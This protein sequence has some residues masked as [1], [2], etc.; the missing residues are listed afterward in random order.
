MGIWHH[1]HACERHNRGTPAFM[2][3]GCGCQDFSSSS[4]LQ[5]TS[6]FNFNCAKQLPIST[7]P[8]VHASFFSNDFSIM[9]AYVPS[10]G[11][12][13][14]DFSMA[15]TSAAATTTLDGSPPL[16][17]ADRLNMLLHR[18]RQPSPIFE[19]I[20]HRTYSV[21]M[22]L[23]AEVLQLAAAPKYAAIKRLLD[24]A[25]SGT[26]AS[27]P[28]QSKQRTT[29]KVCEVLEML[30]A[31]LG[32]PEQAEGKKRKKRRRS[33]NGML[34]PHEVKQEP[35]LQPAQG[36]G[37]YPHKQ[38]SKPLADVVHL[39]YSLD[40]TP[41]RKRKRSEPTAA[42]SM[43][44][45]IIPD[46]NDDGDYDKSHDATGG[47]LFVSE[48]ESG[49]HTDLDSP[50]SDSEP[51]G[52]GS[53]R[54]AKQCSERDI[55]RFGYVSGIFAQN[56]L[57]YYIS[58]EATASH[59][60]LFR[61]TT[62]AA[63][64]YALISCRRASRAVWREQWYA[65]TCTIPN[66]T[67]ALLERFAS[68]IWCAVNG[69]QEAV[70]YPSEGNGAYSTT[71]QSSRAGA[72]RSS[73]GANQYEMLLDNLLGLPNSIVV[74]VCDERWKSRKGSEESRAVT[75]A[76][77]EPDPESESRAATIAKRESESELEPE[78]EARLA[79][80][81]SSPRS[82]MEAKK[83]TEKSAAGTAAFRKEMAK[84]R[85][86]RM[87]NSVVHQALTPPPLDLSSPSQPGLKTLVVKLNT[88]DRRAAAR[89]RLDDGV[90]P[91]LAARRRPGEQEDRDAF[92]R[93][94]E[95]GSCG[96][97][98][99]RGIA[100]ITP[101]SVVYWAGSVSS[102]VVGEGGSLLGGLGRV[103]AEE[104]GKSLAVLGVLVDTELDVLAERTIELVELLLVFGNLLAV[105][106]VLHYR[107]C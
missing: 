71:F 32:V 53:R 49:G 95:I 105:L 11:P 35:G 94:R 47:G 61:L 8:S 67:S 52:E 107:T 54:G 36:V 16:K 80:A 96:A 48:S 87:R 72:R 12:K 33:G 13:Q 41:S 6:N 89:R 97:P 69:E 88:P 104:L 55:S 56:S 59:S 92:G 100:L 82:R 19:T 23:P 24:N 22:R 30:C 106:G 79:S 27:T 28:V 73:A 21:K 64:Y 46:D 38:P 50:S 25:C 10:S 62:F 29:A 81:S 66:W 90:T 43:Q 9:S 57:N 74:E 86:G 58:S 78:R 60:A 63:Q 37:R 68:M 26:K 98:S 77:G 14:Q 76:E 5:K 3:V 70:Q 85:G 91:T 17:P 1:Y 39:E 34:Q 51:E 65:T 84:K 101:G 44:S 7:I 75:V 103:V 2:V 40:T 4:R 93:K 99:V 15:D 45:I 83:L 18:L 102:D 42:Q 20:E 31:A